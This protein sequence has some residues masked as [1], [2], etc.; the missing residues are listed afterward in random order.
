M[1]FR[2][3]NKTL[4]CQLNRHSDSVLNSTTTEANT[5]RRLRKSTPTSKRSRNWW[6]R[7]LL[8]AMRWEALSKTSDS[9]RALSTSFRASSKLSA[10][11]S[12]RPERSL[13]K[14]RLLGRDSKEKPTTTLRRWPTKSRDSISW[15]KRRMLRSEP[16]AVRFRKLS[17]TSD[18]Q[19]NRHKG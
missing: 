11:I 7:T 3:P 5:V 10:A 17:R 1:R 19:L 9:L 15:S 12:M 16:L 6:E 14:L 18:C 8:L 13:L 2:K 4:D